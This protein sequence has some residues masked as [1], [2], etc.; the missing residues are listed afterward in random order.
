MIAEISGAVAGI[1]SAMDIAG[2]MLSLNSKTEIQQAIIDIQRALLDA[3]SSL[4]ADKQIIH[5]LVNEINSLKYIIRGADEWKETANRYRLAESSFGAFYY[6]LL[7]EHCQDEP[8]HRLCVD[9]F[10]ERKKGFLQT[11]L[12]HS[13]GE[14]VKCSKCNAEFKLADFPSTIE[15]FSAGRRTDYSGY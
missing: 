4:Q 8:Y 3:Q 15:V 7:K 12:K 11:T 2:G 10:G 13:G 9:C 14:K 6:D 1:K 5:E